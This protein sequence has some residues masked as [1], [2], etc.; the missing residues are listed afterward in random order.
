MTPSANPLP[1]THPRTYMFRP[2]E[3]CFGSCFLWLGVLWEG[4]T[5]IK[6][7]QTVLWCLFVVPPVFPCSSMS[8][9]WGTLSLKE[10]LC[11]KFDW[12]VREPK[13]SILICSCFK[14]NQQIL[15]LAWHLICL[16]SPG[17]SCHRVFKRQP[18]T[19]ACPPPRIFLSPHLPLSL[20]SLSNIYSWWQIR[21]FRLR[22][23]QCQLP[24]T[25]AHNKV[26]D[27]FQA[28]KIVLFGP[29]PNPLLIGGWAAERQ[30]TSVLAGGTRSNSSPQKLQRF[31]IKNCW[32]KHIYPFQPLS[33]C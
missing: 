18:A 19:P 13:T 29:H 6:A 8:S 12:P 5:N 17:L 32:H 7:V 27:A 16:K 4:C 14:R 10:V 26:E 30:D 3:M 1:A 20:P 9:W 2:P 23:S 22:T 21:L 11:C 31:W 28:G 24:Q 33:T 15:R 25:F